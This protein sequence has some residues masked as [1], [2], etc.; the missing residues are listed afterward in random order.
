MSIDTVYLKVAD[1]SKVLLQSLDFRLKLLSS[2]K[3]LIEN[4]CV[5]PAVMAFPCDFAP[6][7]S[8]S[9]PEETPRVIPLLS[10]P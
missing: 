8:G 7:Q 4:C 1:I 10:V 5:R 9:K 2:F 3:I 6:F